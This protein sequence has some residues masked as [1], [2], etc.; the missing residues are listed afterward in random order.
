V[1]SVA[2]LEGIDKLR[3]DLREAAG[4][5]GHREARFLVDAYYTLQT[6]RIEAANQ[7]RALAENEEPNA[8]IAWLLDQHALLENEIKKALGP[9]TDAHEVGV[10]AKSITGIGPVLSAGLL[11]HIDIERSETVGQIWRFAGLDPTVRWER[12]QKRPW[13]A[14]LKV[15]CWKIGESFVKVA[16]RD[17][18]VYGKV[19]AER[20]LQEETKNAAGD[21]ADQAARAL[22]EKK[23]SKSTEA[24]KAYAEGRLPQARIHARAK[25]YAVKLFLSHWHWVA[26]ESRFETPPM[27]YII[28]HGGHTHFIKPPNWPLA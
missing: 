28:Q 24:Y 3:R 10:W 11:A 18:D 6:H 26:Y 2:T 15:L 8:V 1:T 27:P 22:E 25:R 14:Q 7:V 5:L 13:N 21:F 19:Y 23:Y 20:K 9:Y 12:G 16:H 4:G 17:S